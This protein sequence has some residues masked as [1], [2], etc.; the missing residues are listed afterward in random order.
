MWTELAFSKFLQL[1][2]IFHFIENSF[3]Y[4]N[5]PPSPSSKGLYFLGE[6]SQD[7]MLTISSTPMSTHPPD[8]LFNPTETEQKL[9]LDSQNLGDFGKDKDHLVYKREI[10]S[11]R[12]DNFLDW[13]NHK[14]LMYKVN[15][16][17]KTCNY[18]HLFKL[19]SMDHTDKV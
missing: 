9:D 4:I 3:A 5:P 12:N 11:E 17:K 8:E 6:N 16:T 18:S 2:I 10:K 15:F 19:I 14:S 13:V 1:L 7:G